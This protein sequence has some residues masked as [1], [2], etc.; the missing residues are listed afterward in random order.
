M[1]SE[2]PKSVLGVVVSTWTTDRPSSTAPRRWFTCV[3]SRALT[4]VEVLT[5]VW[6][7]AHTQVSVV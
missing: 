4:G 3:R 6:I 2:L 7:S 5:A 1:S